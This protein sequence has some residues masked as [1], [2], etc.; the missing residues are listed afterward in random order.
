M[1]EANAR[2]LAE[3][4]AS[5]SSS[6]PTL[7]PVTAH[8]YPREKAPRPLSPPP[9]QQEEPAVRPLRIVKKSQ[10]AAYN[11]AAEAKSHRPNTLP[12]GPSS[13]DERSSLARSFSV[14]T[15]GRGTPPP[16]FEPVG[17]N[18][19]GPDYD[20]VA[21]NYVPGGPRRSSPMSMLS[22]DSYRPLPPPR[23]ADSRPNMVM[24]PPPPPPVQHQ[25]AQGPMPTQ[26]QRPQYQRQPRRR[27]GFDPMSAYKSK[28]AFTPGLEPTPERVNPSSFYKWVSSLLYFTCSNPY[29][30]TISSAVSAHLST[31]P[32]RSAITPAYRP[33][34]VY[35]Q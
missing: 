4:P 33:N 12:G 11:K 8:Q 6:A 10:T 14:L 18:L 30:P 15:V 25:P 29:Q 3:G 26:A 20:E 27:I 16:M 34:G 28:S 13:S 5:S 24:P 1:F 21:V 32:Q 7:P 9:P 19:D 22:T 2:V 23:L 31:V 35:Q 17:P